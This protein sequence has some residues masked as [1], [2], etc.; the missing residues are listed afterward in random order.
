M[1]QLPLSM[2][3]GNQEAV[4][5]FLQT[6]CTPNKHIGD[7]KADRYISMQA[8]IEFLYTRKKE[9]EKKTTIF[10]MVSSPTFK[11]SG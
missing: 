9:E 6:V 2:S 1:H 10:K 5:A 11:C 8:T 4:M 7:K 3:T